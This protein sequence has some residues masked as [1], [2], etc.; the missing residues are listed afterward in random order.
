M[1]QRSSFCAYNV[2]FAFCCKRAPCHL[3][4]GNLPAFGPVSCLVASYHVHVPQTFYTP[5][6]L[7]YGLALLSTARQ[8]TYFLLNPT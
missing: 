5:A 2:I 3:T 7:L 1:R 6:L 8:T 4:L